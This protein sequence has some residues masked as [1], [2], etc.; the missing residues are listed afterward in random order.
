MKTFFWLFLFGAS[1]QNAQ[2]QTIS[3]PA[4]P[5]SSF[6]VFVYAYHP[7]QVRSKEASLR[8]KL[9][10]I[11]HK[12]PHDTLGIAILYRR[13]GV[14][15]LILAQHD[16]ARKCHQASLRLLYALSPTPE[17]ELAKTLHNYS[18]NLVRIPAYDSVFWCLEKSLEI[19]SHIYGA[20]DEN[21]AINYCFL[22]GYSINVGKFAKGLEYAEKA[23]YIFRR[24]GKAEHPYMVR[25]LQIR[26]VLH[27]ECNDS[28]AALRDYYE[29]EKIAKQTLDPL[30]PLLTNIYSAIGRTL[31]FRKDYDGALDYLQRCL[32]I[33]EQTLGP[34]HELTGYTFQTLGEVSLAL[35]DTTQAVYYFEKSFE[36][37]EKAYSELPLDRYPFVI[38][39]Y[40]KT[41][42]IQKATQVFQHVYE[43]YKIDDFTRKDIAYCYGEYAAALLQKG[44]FL[45]SLDW[46]TKEKELLL[47]QNPS[48]PYE[49]IKNWITITTC[50]RKLNRLDDAEASIQNIFSS[51][52]LLSDLLQAYTELGEI[53]LARFA[54]SK[55]PDNLADARENF[56][57]ALLYMDSIRYGVIATDSRLQQANQNFHVFDKAIETSVLGERPYEAF[58]LSEKNKTQSLLEHIQNNEALMSTQL[59]D[60]LLKIEKKLNI[61]IAD[62]EKRIYEKS[63]QKATED[64][65]RLFDL[66]RTRVAFVDDLEKNYP[67]YHHLKYNIKQATVRT[68]QQQLLNDSTALIEYFTGDSTLIT[69]TLT[70]DSLYWYHRPKIASLEKMALQLRKSI[71][72]D[73][74]RYTG[75]DYPQF[76]V[77][78]KMLYDY[79]LAAPLSGLSPKVKHLI[80]VADGQLNYIPFE[81]L[82]KANESNVDFRSYPYLLR[83]YSISY[84]CSANLLLEQVKQLQNLQLNPAPHLF[85]GFA[86]IYTDSDTLSTTGSRFRGLLVRNG[87]YGLPGAKKEVEEISRLMSGDAYFAEQA[88]KSNFKKQAQNYRILHLAM[89]SLLEDNNPLFS[90]LLFTQKQQDIVGDNELMAIELYTIHLAAELVVLSA[91]NTAMGKLYKGEGI[92]NLSRAF[93]A[94]GV[95]S[96]VVSLWQSPDEATR[97][98]M[99]RFYQYLKQGESKDSAL[100]LS[101]LD[102]LKDPKNAAL[103]NPYFWAGFIGQGAM[104]PISGF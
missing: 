15:N 45:E 48:K 88:D 25:A 57:T 24:C 37:I 92:L 70:Y 39:L 3:R 49:L 28:D 18:T 50:Q 93:M 40:R 35:H 1:V 31:G 23:V 61:E 71:T 85:A 96:T 91:C 2:A 53:A 43:R 6:D 7:E 58:I 77:S 104:P 32:F 89:H 17:A 83:N 59:P 11:L 82:G 30:H 78:A 47:I 20:D 16:D 97:Q 86:P 4:L 56:N 51:G 65:A 27:D 36:I 19:N 81:V 5:D 99:I 101:K 75:E 38:G 87:Q 33:R 66:K 64:N 26:G 84:A 10:S 55:S 63:A 8:I 80:I 34:Q 72:N 74:L 44:L 9:D 79:L 94:T 14:A 62:L 73:Q 22:A 41:G 102:F 68:L 46:L 12:N 42:N 13:L 69:F 60:S 95:P 54:R 103:A 67:D 21:V 100:Q 52:P 98:V 90:R 76:S 29:A